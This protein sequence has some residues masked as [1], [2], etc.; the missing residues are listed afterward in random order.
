MTQ[1]EAASG[2]WRLRVAPI[3]ETRVGPIP[4]EIRSLG[5]AMF[6]IESKTTVGPELGRLQVR[7][8]LCGIP[9]VLKSLMGRI[10]MAR[11]QRYAQS[12]GAM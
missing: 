5:T 7:Q 8:V 6:G 10:S 11:T 4:S 2:S 12:H 9:L 1:T 3:L